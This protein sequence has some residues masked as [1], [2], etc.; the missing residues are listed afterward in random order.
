[1]CAER[2]QK[3]HGTREK[4]VN[5][6]QVLGLQFFHPPCLFIEGQDTFL[7]SYHFLPSEAWPTHV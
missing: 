3:D 5:R 7:N 2:P 4:S 1:M 6:V